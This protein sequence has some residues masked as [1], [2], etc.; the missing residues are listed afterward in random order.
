MFGRLKNIVWAAVL[1]IFFSGAGVVVA[2]AD[3]NEQLGTFAASCSLFGLT[4]AV[5]ARSA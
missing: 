2:I 5:L 4:L 1:S 3:S